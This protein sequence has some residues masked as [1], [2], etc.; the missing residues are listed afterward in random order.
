[1]GTAGEQSAAAE[2]STSSG[3][4]T[5][6]GAGPRSDQ[7][8]PADT[9]PGTL[10]DKELYWLRFCCLDNAAYHAMR[11]G[12]Y[13]K[14][15]RFIMAVIV[16]SSS[17]TIASFAGVARFSEWTLWLGLVPLF[18]STSDLVFGPGSKAQTHAALRARYFELLADIEEGEAIEPNCRRWTAALHRAAAQEPP[19]TYRAVKAMSYNS[20]VDSLWPEV[21]AKQRRLYIPWY[22]R[23]RGRF[24]PLHAVSYKPSTRP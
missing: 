5:E 23:L 10:R 4:S 8:L 17:G 3:T 18:A 9:P 6:S 7:G 1:V 2:P 24:F 13:E 14:L 15:H 21:E 20:A 12:Y 22:D 16:I 19:I 11:S